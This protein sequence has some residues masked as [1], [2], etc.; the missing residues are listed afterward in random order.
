MEYKTSK[1]C[2]EIIDA[3]LV[4]NVSSTPVSSLTDQMYLVG[5][6]KAFITIQCDNKGEEKHVFCIK[7]IKKHKKYIKIND[8][9]K[10]KLISRACKI[11]LQ[12]FLREQEKIKKINNRFEK[13]R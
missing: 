2:G 8:A 6:G 11:R 7:Y 3:L 5:N 10:A 13:V 4:D 1:D 9:Q 12:A